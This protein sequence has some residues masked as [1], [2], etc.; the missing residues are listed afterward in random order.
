MHLRHLSQEPWKWAPRLTCAR[1][2]EPASCAVI[3]NGGSHFVD[4][5]VAV[6][7]LEGK[8]W[9]AAFNS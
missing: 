6:R 9:G 4:R 1:A 3:R 8:G 7:A 2:W 5:A